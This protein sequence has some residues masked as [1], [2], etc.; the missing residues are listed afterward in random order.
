MSDNPAI[1]APPVSLFGLMMQNIALL[2][3]GQLTE[4]LLRFHGANVHFHLLEYS[5]FPGT[6]AGSG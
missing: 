1:L 4:M 5:K 6:T 3:A 2:F